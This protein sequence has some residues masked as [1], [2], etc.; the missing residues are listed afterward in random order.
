MR[1]DAANPAQGARSGVGTAVRTERLPWLVLGAEESGL[2]VVGAAVV[3]P[4]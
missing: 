1:A 2:V 4:Q 3:M